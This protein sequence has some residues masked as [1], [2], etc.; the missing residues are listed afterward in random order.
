MAEETL[1]W[2]G[3]SA[4]FFPERRRH[5]LAVLHAY[6]LYRKECAAGGPFAQP[7]VEVWEGEGGRSSPEADSDAKRAA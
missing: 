4:C 1:D 5:D 6:E 2:V 3:F 7:N